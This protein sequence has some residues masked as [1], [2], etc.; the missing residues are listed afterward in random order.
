MVWACAP[1]V[2]ELGS[3]CLDR[4]RLAAGELHLSSDSKRDQ[5]SARLVRP[6]TVIVFGKLKRTLS[7]PTL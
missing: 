2:F 6:P 3:V 7:T 1:V 4:W 5:V